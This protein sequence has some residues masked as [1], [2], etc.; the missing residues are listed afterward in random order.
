[1]SVDRCIEASSHQRLFDQAMASAEAIW[2]NTRQA[3]LVNVRTI[4]LNQKANVSQNVVDI[5]AQQ[6]VDCLMR[7]SSADPNSLGNF[8][9]L[10]SDWHQHLYRL[11]Q[12]GRQNLLAELKSLHSSSHRSDGPA[13][14]ELPRSPDAATFANIMLDYL[15][16]NHGHIRDQEPG[17]TEQ[18]LAGLLR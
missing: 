1:M 3:L 11:W 18:Q 5:I 14:L 7:S 9:Q 13:T 15:T 16:R 4:L 17:Q 8:P 6:I 12:Q 10:D 2:Q